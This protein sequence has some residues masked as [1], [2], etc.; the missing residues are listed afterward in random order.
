MN[1]EGKADKENFT[2]KDADPRELAMGVKVEM[3]H[4]NDP[5]LAR[6]IA[7]DHLAEFSNYYTRL[8][9]ME[10]GAM[11]KS[12]FE[13][14]GD[15]LLKSATLEDGRLVKALPKAGVEG[16]HKT[17]PKEYREGGAKKEKQYADPKNFKYPIDDEGHVRA[18]ISYFS[19]P[20]NAGVY[21]PEQQK[22]IWSRI[23]KAA[24]RFGIETGK[25]SGP[26]SVE[27]SLED[28]SA[29]L[30]E[31]LLKGFD[32]SKLTQKQVTVKRG[33]KTFQRKQ[34]VSTGE[35]PED[36]GA[37]RF[38]G[39]K[40]RTDAIAAKVKGMQ[41]GVDFT[42]EMLAKKPW[43]RKETVE[44]F[45]PKG[46]PFRGEK[47]RAAHEKTK[48]ASAEERV[49]DL[50]RRA[51]AGEKGLE[52][53]Y[54][55]WRKKKGLKDLEF[56]YNRWRDTVED[57]RRHDLFYQT[58]EGK[59][60]RKHEESQ[61]RKAS[62]QRKKEGGEVHGKSFLRKSIFTDDD[63][64]C[65]LEDG[66]LVK[67]F[68]QQIAQTLGSKAPPKPSTAPLAKLQT[69]EPRPKKLVRGAGASSM[70]TGTPIAQAKPNQ[71]PR[72]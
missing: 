59:A 41:A 56:G 49:A 58:P 66:R 1:M 7:L 33:G 31:S 25:E 52:H 37:A 50:F 60:V 24:K 20:K 32:R 34:W 8:K 6:K 15:D 70:K 3:E 14:D 19:K 26:P 30:E 71:P 40:E 44:K 21:S 16:G 67:A 17:P 28:A 55:T 35:K 39:D 29:L 9:K 4:T 64:N 69:P 48:G 11:K 22:S 38:V 2:E 57:K 53:P 51:E 72:G 68:P 10:A 45:G 13:K 47:A 54:D 36:T 63:L 5:K 12:V 46:E 61:A 65:T 27:K 42:N 23:R 62:Y 18:A 43:T